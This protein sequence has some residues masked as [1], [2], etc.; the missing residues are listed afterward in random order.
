MTESDGY[1]TV[2]C[3][4]WAKRAPQASPLRTRLSDDHAKAACERFERGASLRSIAIRFRATN[5]AVM[6]ALQEGLAED[7]LDDEPKGAA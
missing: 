1:Q 6:A 5:E 2:H 3:T 7:W 4:G